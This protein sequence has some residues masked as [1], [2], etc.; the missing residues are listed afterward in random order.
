MRLD[1]ES[2]PDVFLQHRKANVLVSGGSFIAHRMILYNLLLMLAIKPPYL[3]WPNKHTI[4]SLFGWIVLE[5]PKHSLVNHRKFMSL[6]SIP[7]YAEKAIT[8]SQRWN[9]YLLFLI[10]KHL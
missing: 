5:S 7:R 8:V 3:Y 10:L 9:V 2:C 6:S 1:N 4:K